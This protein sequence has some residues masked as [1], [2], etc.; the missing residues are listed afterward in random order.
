MTDVQHPFSSDRIAAVADERGVDET[1][2][3]RA[4][5]DVQDAIS[6]GTGD[7][8]EYSSQ[9]N[10][11]WRDEEAYYLYGDGIWETLRGELSLSETVADAAREVHRRKMV[12]SA[13]ERGERESF[14]EM[15]ADETEPLVVVDTASDPPLYGQD[16]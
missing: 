10:Y 11:G 6:R 13:E 1:D 16:V 9:H 2:L 15:L 3:D 4:L 5:A 8:Y 7:E 12:A 14:E